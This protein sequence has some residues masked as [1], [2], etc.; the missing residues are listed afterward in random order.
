MDELTH[1]RGAPRAAQPFAKPWETESAPN[2]T[3]PLALQAQ[4]QGMEWLYTAQQAAEFDQYAHT[5]LGFPP[6][7]L[8][9]LA[10]RA[11]A[12]R[13]QRSPGSSKLTK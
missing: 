8:M 9:A 13:V 2:S 12:A 11:I 3:A 4:R 10:G 5:A 7:V 6:H 1:H